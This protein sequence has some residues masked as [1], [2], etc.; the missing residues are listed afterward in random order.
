[1]S[2][3]LPL[4]RARRR[5]ENSAPWPADGRA[6]RAHGVA[7]PFH[8][9][10]A[11]PPE[12]AALE[13]AGVPLPTL[14][15]A[16]RVAEASGV[17]PYDA[18]ATA[19]AIPE[20]ELVLKLADALGVDAL[21]VDDGAGS[22]FD[23][24]RCGFALRTGR[25]QTQGADGRLRLVI[26]ARGASVAALARARR[27]QPRDAKIALATPRAFAD[28][29]IARTGS[30]L[31]ERA[32]EGP[33]ALS[34]E[35]TVERGMPRPGAAMRAALAAGLIAMVAAAFLAPAAGIALAA[36]TGLLFAALNAFRLR[37]ACTSA[38]P[39]PTGARLDDRALPIYTV[40]VPLCREA[41]VVPDLLAALERFDY[42]PAKLDIKL[43]VERNDAETLAALAR[44]PPRAGVEVLVLP[45][46]G[47][48]TKPR[49][50]NAGLLAARGAYLT[51]Y[52]AEDRPD[53]DQLRLAVA[54][55]RAGPGKLAC[56]QAKLAIDNLA[57]GWLVRHFAIEYAALF[58]VAIP[59]LASLGLPIP[60]GGTSNHFRGLMQQT[61]FVIRS[62]TASAGAFC[63]H[64]NHCA[65]RLRPHHFRTAEE[66]R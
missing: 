61:H 50:L 64:G 57:D 38:P 51:I 31:A 35:L 1:M 54:A 21:S 23:A 28:W 65:S 58:D 37:L 27:G 43:L 26:A 10:H 24:D 48:Q 62:L 49:A 36:V 6:S 46:G 60:L 66:A 13:R 59:A 3:G 30:A 32:S 55:F 16:L 25:V 33:A 40:L 18:L 56:V 41:A 52:D 42:P 63:G 12:L 34:P 15:D 39:A 44:R 5:H 53:P 7:A 47:P 9:R 22:T 45:P 4:S 8:S 14:L 19:A 20:E 17:A 2:A 11:L 29:V